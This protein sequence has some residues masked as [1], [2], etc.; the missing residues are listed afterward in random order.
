MPDEPGG[1]GVPP[2]STDSPEDESTPSG[3][4]IA[5]DGS[6]P[7]AEEDGIETSPS[8]KPADKDAIQPTSGKLRAAQTTESEDP[9]PTEKPN[10]NRH[11]RSNPNRPKF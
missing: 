4:Q 11:R 3:D 8:A 2:A 5:R 10:P 1:A 9:E 7:M 6:L